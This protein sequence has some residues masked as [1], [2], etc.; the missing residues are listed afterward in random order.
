MELEIEKNWNRISE[1]S[2]PGRARDPTLGVELKYRISVQNHFTSYGELPPN[3]I[4]VKK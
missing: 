3:Y 4:P 2:R 1:L